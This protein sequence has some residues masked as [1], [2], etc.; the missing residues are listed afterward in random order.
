MD[1]KTNTW[2]W[3]GEV[4]EWFHTK[5]ETRESSKGRE[6]KRMRDEVNDNKSRRSVELIRCGISSVEAAGEKRERE[7]KNKEYL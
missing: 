3:D 2:G 7:T 4:W 1:S 5:M 6:E